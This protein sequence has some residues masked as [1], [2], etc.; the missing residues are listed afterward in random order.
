MSY[1]GNTNTT[2]AFT[3]AV[4]FFSGNASTTAFT[5]SRPVASVAQVQAVIS[6][7]PQDPG[8]AYT[9]S[10][11][12]ITFTS[13]PPSGTNNI[14][15]YYTSPITQVIAP[16]QGTVGVTQLSSTGTPSSTTFLRG[17]NTWASVSQEV[18]QC[19]LVYTSATVLTLTPVNGQ[20]I[21]IAGSI[22]AIPS[23]GVTLSNSGLSVS[24]RYYIYANIS[25]GNVTLSAS[26]T[27]YATDTTAGNVGVRIKSGDNAFTLVGMIYT[28]A[29]SQFVD[30]AASR[31][32]LSYFNRQ[33]KPLA[34]TAG[35]TTTTSTS[36]VITSTAFFTSLNWADEGLCVFLGAQFNTT[37][38]FALV[39]AVYDSASNG[40][41]I[42]Q[43]IYGTAPNYP[44]TL[45][46]WIVPAEGLH[47]YYI[48]AGAASGSGTVSTLNPS[49][50]GYV[51][52]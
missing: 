28:N 50:T 42:Y 6:N 11:N 48:A 43:F 10:G 22:Y 35:N 2:Q 41:G 31:Q 32:V 26:A 15:V 16:S 20:F 49:G 29:S 4:D 18:G 9:V 45:G 8:S 39:Q 5:L 30:T 27:A 46:G 47:T 13:A 24:T 19:R 17:D 36:Q 37:G 7:V 38:S 3:P 34:G 12:T 33:Q 14:Y 1:I 44:A 40:V 51:N 21:K 23:A 25:G 52:G